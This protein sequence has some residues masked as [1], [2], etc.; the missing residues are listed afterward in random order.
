[1]FYDPVFSEASG[2]YEAVTGYYLTGWGCFIG[3]AVVG[4][5][6]SCL[7]RALKRRRLET[8]GDV[9]AIGVLRP[10]FRFVVALAAGLLLSEL[11]TGLLV[12]GIDNMG[13]GGGRS[14]RSS[15]CSAAPSAGRGGDAGAKSF[16]VFK[17]PLLGGPGRALA[18]AD[19]AALRLRAGRHGL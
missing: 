7:R 11:L 13:L 5:L 15:C 2:G 10:V 17:W 4:A 16:R 18:A 3:Y 8:A 14:L 19:G 1:M 6:L 12:P 9:V